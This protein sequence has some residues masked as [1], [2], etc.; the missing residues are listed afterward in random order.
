MYQ[1]RER[2]HV[3][4]LLLSCT[5]LNLNVYN[6]CTLCENTLS[7]LFLLVESYTYL[8]KVMFVRTPT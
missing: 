4:I 2:M 3:N 1:Y 6:V 5:L 8:L 7:V